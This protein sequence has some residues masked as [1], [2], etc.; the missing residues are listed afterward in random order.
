[1][2]PRP[3]SSTDQA[4]LVSLLGVV[5]AVLG[6]ILNAAGGVHPACWK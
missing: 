5:L 6:E 1:M 4:S 2:Q 3:N